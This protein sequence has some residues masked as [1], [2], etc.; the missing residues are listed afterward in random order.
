MVASSLPALFIAARFIGVTLRLFPPH[1]WELT[2]N[3][4]PSCLQLALIVRPSGA[5]VSGPEP[6]RLQAEPKTPTL[7]AAMTDAPTFLVEI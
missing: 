3:C 5:P 4:P 6:W 7:L 1:L 2:L